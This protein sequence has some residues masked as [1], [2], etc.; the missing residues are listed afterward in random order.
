MK[1][2]ILSSKRFS[3]AKQYLS[4]Q[5][6]DHA[7]DEYKKVF[8]YSETEI[9]CVTNDFIEAYLGIATVN[10]HFI[11]KKD[12]NRFEQDFQRETSKIKI[13]DSQKHGLHNRYSAKF[14]KNKMINDIR[15]NAQKTIE[16]YEQNQALSLNQ[17]HYNKAKHILESLDKILATP[18]IVEDQSTPLSGDT[19]SEHSDS[20]HA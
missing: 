11:E 6:Y 18:S 12:F 7:L 14:F 17:D 2:K 13:S 15:F 16:L 8:I 5:N 10:M 20:D 3:L 19:S 4:S 9:Q 1:K